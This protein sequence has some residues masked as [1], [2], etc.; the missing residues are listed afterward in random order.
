M[1]PPTKDRL[2]VW[3]FVVLWLLPVAYRGLTHRPPPAL[4]RSMAR[5]SNISCLFSRAMPTWSAFYVQYRD[6]PNG[7]WREL[8][9]SAWFEMK[10][11]GHR[12][13]L[14]RYLVNWPR[15]ADAARQELADWLAAAYRRDF[16]EA[17]APIEIRFVRAR[18]GVRDDA[19]PEGPWERPE[20]RTIPAN[21]LEVVSTHAVEDAT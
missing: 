8:D 3:L 14:H 10:P 12:T 2:A 19:R 16:P 5:L 21:H 17:R 20:L 1:R 13:R 18:I 7:P 11:F 6:V 4:P 9:T 15:K